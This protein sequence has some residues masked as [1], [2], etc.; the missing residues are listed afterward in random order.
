MGTI[1][2]YKLRFPKNP[3]REGNLLYGVNRQKSNEKRIHRAES[4][5]KPRKVLLS[6]RDDNR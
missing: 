3:K 4:G 1:K 5:L 2:N 6:F